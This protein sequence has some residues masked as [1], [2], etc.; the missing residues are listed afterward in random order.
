MSYLA[1]NKAPSWF[2]IVSVS[3]L[4]SEMS[5]AGMVMP[6]TVIII[7]VVQVMLAAGTR[8]YRWTA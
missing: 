5:P 6:V 7:A 3:L 1:K 8:A 2:M 4:L